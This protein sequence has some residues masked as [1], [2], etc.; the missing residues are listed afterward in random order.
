MKLITDKNELK[1][2]Y[3]GNRLWQGIAS[4]EKTKNGR[5]FCVFYSGGVR[6]MY[7]NYAVMVKSDDDGKSWSDAITVVVPDDDN[8][9]IFDDNV[10]LA[11]DGKLWFWWSQ[12]PNHAVFASVC[13]NP[14]DDCLLWSEPKYIGDGVM[15]NKPIVISD[16]SWLFP[17]A[18]WHA[19]V[20]VMSKIKEDADK[21]AFVYLTTDCGKTFRKL[22]GVDA[23]KR[24]FDEHI[25]VENSD[26]SLSMYIRT[27]YGIA[28]SNSF[29]GGKSWTEAQ[30]SGIAGPNSRFFI[31][32]LKSGRFL[33]VNHYN[34]TG[35]NNMTAMLSEDD[36][37]TWLE[38]KLLL[39]A[40]NVSYPDGTQDDDGFIYVV[41]DHE[42][43]YADKENNSIELMERAKRQILMYKFCE[44]DILA[45]RLVNPKSKLCVVVSALG[46]FTGDARK[47]KWPL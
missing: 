46:K 38:T 14:D 25:V 19:D 17:I 24:C 10:W 6:E 5:L 1:N 8:H 42:R 41:C 34:F 2:Y 35:R 11:P 44:E 15:M 16:S 40:G 23:P 22:G 13:E 36:G 4:M 9:R 37:K 26:K 18:L 33:L 7:G 47:V 27:L 21:K 45:G 28:K 31:R 3:S 39:D 43:G 32:R 12:E 30:D 29:D 20:A